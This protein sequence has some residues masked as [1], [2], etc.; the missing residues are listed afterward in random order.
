MGLLE[1]RPAQNVEHVEPSVAP[2]ATRLGFLD[3]PEQSFNRPMVFREPSVQRASCGPLVCKNLVKRQADRQKLTGQ[4]S[5]GHVSPTV[6]QRCRPLRAP[7]VQHVP[8]IGLI[9]PTTSARGAIPPPSAPL[10]NSD[11]TKKEGG[12]P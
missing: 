1:A 6:T 2:A 4:L 5:V 8:G 3:C 12:P 11:P 10:R 7:P 9:P